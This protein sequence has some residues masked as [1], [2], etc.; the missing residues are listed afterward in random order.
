MTDPKL[1]QEQVEALYRHHA[2]GVHRFLLGVLRDA[3]LVDEALQQTFVRVLERGHTADDE[4]MKGWIYKVAFNQAMALRRQQRT[5]GR[6]FGQLAIEPELLRIAHLADA[7]TDEIVIENETIE[8]ARDAVAELPIEQQEV[9][10]LR[11]SEGM[12]FATIADKI[13][14]PLGTALTRMRL[15]LQKLRRRMQS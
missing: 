15:A 2:D 5:G 7:R 8:R 1:A 9:L 12:T 3:D 14:V 13:G 4:T 6:V 11:F 10:Q